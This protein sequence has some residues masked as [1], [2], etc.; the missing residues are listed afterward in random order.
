MTAWKLGFV[1]S[2]SYLPLH[3][4]KDPQRG[5]LGSKLFDDKAFEILIWMWNWE[6]SVSV[7]LFLSQ[8]LHMRSEKRSSED[9]RGRSR[10]CSGKHLCDSTCI[11][12]HA[13]ESVYPPVCIFASCWG[14]WG[15]QWFLNHC[16]QARALLT[17]P[18]RVNAQKQL[19]TQIRF[20]GKSE[21]H[22]YYCGIN[23]DPHSASVWWCSL[24]IL[25]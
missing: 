17:M 4:I 25:F 15:T 23:A 6:A 20:S 3:N 12:K 24:Q 22:A 11:Y 21:F 19:S 13:C 2:K 7:F 9:G 18:L 8:L 5:A 16:K 14:R 10:A 1:N